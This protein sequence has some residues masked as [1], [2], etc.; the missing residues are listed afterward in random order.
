MSITRK[1]LKP[2]KTY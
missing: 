1:L 2:S